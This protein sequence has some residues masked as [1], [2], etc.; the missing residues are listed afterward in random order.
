MIKATRAFL[1]RALVSS[2]VPPVLLILLP[3]YVKQYVFSSGFPT[4]VATFLL[5]VLAFIILVLFILMLSPVCADTRFNNNNNITSM[6]LKSSEARAQKRNKTKS[7]IIFKSRGH[8]WPIYFLLH[9][10]WRCDR[11]A[12]SSAKSK[13]S[14]WLHWI[15]FLLFV[16]VVFI[17]QSMATRTLTVIEGTL[18]LLLSLLGTTQ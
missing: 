18:V 13:S 16:V 3:R 1:I 2:S 11:R 15:P 7:V 8:T 12:R 10:S 4:T 5:F 9:L 17:I 14:S 6:A